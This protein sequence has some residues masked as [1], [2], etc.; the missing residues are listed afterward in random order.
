MCARVCE[1]E[2]GV[3]DFVGNRTECA[4]LVML[5]KLGLDYKQLREEREA[6]Q[7]KVSTCVL[8]R[9]C[10]YALAMVACV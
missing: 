4:L 6:D 2:S 1:Q 9:V 7:I 10:E 5:R 3:T 8:A